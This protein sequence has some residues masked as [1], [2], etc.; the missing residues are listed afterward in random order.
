MKRY[1]DFNLTSHTTL[2][3]G[4]DYE[5]KYHII[6]PTLTHWH[7]DFNALVSESLFNVNFPPSD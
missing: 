2:P 6:C 7:S 5:P 1:S 3:T 4:S